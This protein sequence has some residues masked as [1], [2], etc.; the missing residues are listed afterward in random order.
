MESSSEDININEIEPGLLAPDHLRSILEKKG[1]KTNS[2]DSKS[3]LIQLYLRYIKP[4][5]KRQRRQLINKKTSLQLATIKIRKEE[6]DEEINK[7]LK[8]LTKI[9]LK[10]K[11]TNSTQIQTDN[12]TQMIISDQD[13]DCNDTNVKKIKLK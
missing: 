13:D 6:D 7:Q 11:S 2:N 10:R 4:K 1:I 8:S 12:N 9:T 5:E 3:D